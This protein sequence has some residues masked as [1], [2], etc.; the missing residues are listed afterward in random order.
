MQAVDIAIAHVAERNA[1]E[2]E[3]ELVLVEAAQRD[4]HRPFVVAERIGG[5]EIH[6]GQFLD[7]L[8]WAGTGN[9]ARNIQCA[10]ALHLAALA[11]AEHDDLGLSC[12][13]MGCLGRRV[14]GLGGRAGC[15]E[16]GANP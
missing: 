12:F 6:A 4:A 7:C 9:D 5:L 2:R 13:R 11:E 15:H 10:H 1:V 3:A 14:G 8:E 16:E